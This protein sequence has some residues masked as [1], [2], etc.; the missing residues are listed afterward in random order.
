MIF[1][2]KDAAI[3]EFFPKNRKPQFYAALARQNGQKYLT[4]EGPIM[5][6]FPN[7]TPDFGDFLLDAEEFRALM[8]ENF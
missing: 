7:L 4:L 6:T 3:I 8:R 2:P 1:A 5:R